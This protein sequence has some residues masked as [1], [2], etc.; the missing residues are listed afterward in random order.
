MAVPVFQSMMYPLLNYASDH[1]EHQISDFKDFVRNHFNLTSED[2]NEKTS[3]GILRYVSNVQWTITYLYRAG[4]LTRVKRGTYTISSIGVSY[5]QQ[6]QSSQQIC[7]NDL[8]EF[9]SFRKFISSSNDDEDSN[10]TQSEPV[11]TNL[12]EKTPDESIEESYKLL[13]STL[14]EELLNTIKERKPAFFES[15]VVDL[16]IKMGYGGFRKEAGHVVGKSGD[17]GIDGIIN[18][19]KLGL[20][21]ICIQA[22]RYDNDVPVSIS[23]VRAF[24]GALSSKKSHK[25]I[26]LTTSSFP[27]SAYDFVKTCSDHQIALID[28]K[29]LAELMIEH[30]VGVSVCKTYQIKKIDDDYFDDNG[31]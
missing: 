31:M 8:R 26:F 1:K 3:S 16:L 7:I 13:R 21:V 27:K 22:K 12:T 2:L 10:P 24:A 17:G 25:G 9:E 11:T 4:L 5:L 20:D 19:D 18:E 15:L 23:D 30:N 14:A 28:G 29:R 6:K